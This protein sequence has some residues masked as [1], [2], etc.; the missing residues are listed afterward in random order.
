MADTKQ[1]LKVVLLGDSHVGKTSLR[2]QLVHHVFSNAYRA[3]IGGDFL[4]TA[5]EIVGPDGPVT[6]TLQVWD[7]AGQ[8]R[9][10]S[11]VRAFYRGA[12]VAVV[13][14]DLTNPESFQNVARWIEGFLAN[15]HVDRP[16]IVIV[17]NKSDRDTERRISTRQAREFAALAS[18]ARGQSLVDRGLIE[19]LDLDVRDCCAK[20][21]AEVRAIFQR[22]AE[23]GVSRASQPALEF[24]CVDISE[25]VRNKGCC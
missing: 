4:T 11:L 2:T 24:D 10:N 7:T 19:D 1:H 17:G 23:L 25:P 22:C 13:V 20:N 9:F 12:D 3:T 8:E 16:A 15:V 21:Y 6:A 5:L 18:V 14:F